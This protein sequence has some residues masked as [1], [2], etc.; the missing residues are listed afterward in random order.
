MS[1]WSKSGGRLRHA[2]VLTDLRCLF[3]MHVSSDWKEVALQG[4]EAAQIQRMWAR[5]NLAVAVGV[6]IRTTAGLVGVSR[7]CVA[8]S[9]L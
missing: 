8:W 7:F 2:S 9:E 4:E 6:E 1:A 5:D 3:R